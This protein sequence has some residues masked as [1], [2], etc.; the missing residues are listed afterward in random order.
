MH[1]GL[2]THSRGPVKGYMQIADHS[3]LE[4]Q[5]HPWTKAPVLHGQA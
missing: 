3:E 1:T 2:E 5:R 4:E